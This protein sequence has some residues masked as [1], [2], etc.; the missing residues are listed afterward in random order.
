MRSLVVVAGTDADAAVHAFDGAGYESRRST[1]VQ[2][3]AEGHQ[4]IA[5]TGDVPAALRDA[6]NRGIKYLLVHVGPDDGLKGGSFERA[7]HRVQS[8]E[9]PQLAARLKPRDRL[10]VVALAFGY[11]HGLPADANWVIDCRMLDNPYWIQ[12]LRD[13]TGR[14]RPVIDFVLGQP[15]ARD[16][17]DGLERTLAAVIPLYA[18]QGRSELVIAFGCTGGRHRS[19]AVAGEMALRLGRIPGIEVETRSRELPG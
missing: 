15:A 7:H 17:I 11:K 4:M 8:G 9:L 16:L 1:A 18:E 19:V 13:L 12:E 2:P 10:L 3:A 14:D 5:L 6:D